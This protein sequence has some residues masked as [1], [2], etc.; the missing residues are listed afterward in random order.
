MRPTPIQDTQANKH[1]RKP[2]GKRQAQEHHQEKPMQYG[3]IKTQAPSTATS[4]YP[5]TPE[6]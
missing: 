3:T 2:D 5:N 1:Q 4:G 6:K